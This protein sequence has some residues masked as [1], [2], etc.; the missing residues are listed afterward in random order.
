MN[1]IIA[2]GIVGFGEHKRYLKKVLDAVN[3]WADIIILLEDKTDP[4]SLKICKSFSKVKLYSHN[5]NECMFNINESLLRNELWENVRKIAKDGDFI[6]SFDMDEIFDKDIKKV[7]EMAEV[8][9]YEK[10]TCKLL[11]M[12][13][14][15]HY[16]IDHFWSP[17]ITR[18]YKFK[19]EDF[20]IKGELHCGCIPKYT[21]KMKELFI[22]RFR[23]K[24]L[25]LISDSEKK[26]KQEFYL[27]KSKGINFEHALDISNK[28]ILIEYNE[29]KKHTKTVT[30]ASLIKNRE[31]CLK[32]F[33]I[34]LGKQTRYYDPKLISFFFIVNDSLD[35]S[36]KIL[37][38]WKEKCQEFYG[39]IEIKE[40][41][42]N[43]TDN[44]EHHW[45][46]AKLRNM[47]Y[48]RD[49]CLQKLKVTDYLFMLDSDIFLEKADTL[50][51]LVALQ[52]EVVY[53]VFWAGWE[54]GVK[55]W[56]QVWQSGGYE[57][58]QE[59]L[60]MLKNP[61][62]YEVGL[63][64]ACTLF[65]KSV[66][67]KGLNYKRVKN[68]PTAMRGEDRDC[69]IRMEVLNIKQWAD[70]YK[71]P[72]HMERS[73]EQKK[74]I[75]AE[76]NE[77][78]KLIRKITDEGKKNI[79]VQNLMKKKSENPNIKISL[80]MMVKNEEKYI[81]G[82]ILSVLP[83]VDEIVVVDTGST[84]KT[85]EILKKYNAKII[86][87]KWDD[88]FSKPRNIGLK[89]CRGNWILRID[90]DE[91]IPISFL[92]Q[93]FDIVS[94][95]SKNTLALLI[96]IRNY[97]DD[98]DK[99]DSD[100]YI[101]ETC[102]I[103]RNRP[104]VFYSKRIHEEID[105]SLQNIAK[106]NNEVIIARTSQ[107]I[108][109]L[110]FMREKDELKQKHENYARISLKQ[111]EENPNDSSTH[112]TLAVHYKVN[113]DLEKAVHHYE[114]A[115]RIQPN[116]S[117]A[118]NDLGVYYFYVGNF[119]K[120]RELFIRAKETLSPTATQ[121]LK[122]RINLN[123]EDIEAVEKRFKSMM[124]GDSNGIQGQSVIFERK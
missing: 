108:V 23:I 2:K 45:G 32:E 104:D 12:W 61:G 106:N 107:Y 36:L 41:N 92:Y 116:F 59:F 85:R 96:P 50:M 103:F 48:M 20:G 102:R 72:I 14:E 58:T 122:K 28:P 121:A 83:L 24:H 40:I 124:A 89:A 118:L 5:F 74:I 113:G 123:M 66:L 15:K 100:F 35:N 84:D 68:L 114:E 13:D 78:A 65:Y 76:I 18:I 69:S 98:P 56:P 91:R 55:K 31:W 60:Q 22:P 94:N 90:A 97:F 26:K 38:E 53:E 25:S 57:L 95:I 37:N 73:E 43:N 71:T 109:H 86:D 39:P 10:V 64:G 17:S 49:L 70:T 67:E 101:S 52:R 6:V 111:L 110:G 3:E 105:E 44:K 75:D 119:K 7:I 21:N 34:G 46:D 33:L 81:E 54:N 16:R 99:G 63:G 47:A 82:A 4:E 11:D 1:R 88:D 19:D 77:K 117:S 30:I 115:I 29:D 80:C 9:G 8:N 93:F 79:I 112:Y 51:H 120:A 62:V 87:Y 27:K 42:F